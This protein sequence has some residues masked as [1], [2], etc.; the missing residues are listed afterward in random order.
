MPS[1][2]GP[3]HRPRSALRCA[4][5]SFMEN[6][7]LVYGKL[8][9]NTCVCF[10]TGSGQ[11]YDYCTIITPK[12]CH[13]TPADDFGTHGGKR[14]SSAE[15][16]RACAAMLPVVRAA[17]CRCPAPNMHAAPTA[18]A[19]RLRG[20]V[21]EAATREGGAWLW[22]R[23]DAAPASNCAQLLWFEPGVHRTSRLHASAGLLGLGRCGLAQKEDCDAH[24]TQQHGGGDDPGV[25][26]AQARS[27]RPRG[28]P[29]RT[30]RIW[31]GGVRVP[32][33]GEFLTLA[34]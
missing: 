19:S 18:C 6:W 28:H 23:G 29:A 12:S 32:C 10:Q 30:G 15:A 16:A 22:M 27:P 33:L 3:M 34:K 1:P 8:V 2:S 26:H 7:Y 20:A 14:R 21:R 31:S 17:S 24:D 25:V 4:S 9:I 11:W 5:R 13:R